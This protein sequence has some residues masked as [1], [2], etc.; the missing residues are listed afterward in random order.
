MITK[1]IITNNVIEVYEMEKYVA[2]RGGKRDKKYT[3]ESISSEIDRNY[4]NHNQVRLN[5]IRRLATANFNKDSLFLTLT[6]D[7]K[8]VAHDIRCPKEC[9]YQ[10]KKFIQRL[11]YSLKVDFKYLAVVEF[12]DLNNRGAVHYHVLIDLPFIDF[13]QLEDIWGMGFIYLNKIDHVDNVGAYI[14]KYIT[15]DG[16]DERLVGEKSYLRSSNLIDP[17]SFI[18]LEDE[19]VD[20]KFYEIDT[21][22]SKIK[23]IYECDYDTTMLGHVKYKQYNLD[24]S[25]LIV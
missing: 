10:F 4:K 12:Q 8:K 6:F 25:D 9:N 17:K 1:Y 19:K 22:L 18:L 3:L 2:G 11:R 13:K 21:I 24:R 20:K 23:T 16:G 7:D 14:V 15:K 5:S